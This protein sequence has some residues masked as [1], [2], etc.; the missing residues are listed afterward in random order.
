[1]KKCSKIEEKIQ[2]K[3]PKYRYQIQLDSQIF[4]DINENEQYITNFQPNNQNK[5]LI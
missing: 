5:E 4:N 3:Y 2:Q 1:M